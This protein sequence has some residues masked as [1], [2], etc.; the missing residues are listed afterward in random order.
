MKHT[1]MLKDQ[2]ALNVLQKMLNT[3][4][5]SEEERSV[6]VYSMNSI[7]R[8]AELETMKE[9]LESECLGLNNFKNQVQKLITK[10]EFQACEQHDNGTCC[11]HPV[12]VIVNGENPDEVGQSG[13]K[14]SD[15][16]IRCNSCNNEFLRIHE[17]GRKIVNL[18]KHQYF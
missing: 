17:K 16:I 1:L 5:L 13:P 6:I 18:S 14:T 10:E 15:L 12:I 9:S 11:Q 4:G 8:A 2:T 7:K 3:R